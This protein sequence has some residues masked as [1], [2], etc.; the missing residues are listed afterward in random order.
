MNTL[1]DTARNTPS[2]PPPTAYAP[3]APSK[4]D[5]GGATAP[6][7]RAAASSTSGDELTET[8]RAFLGRAERFLPTAADLFPQWER[9]LSAYVV[10]FYLQHVAHQ[11][12]ANL[13]LVRPLYYAW[14]IGFEGAYQLFWFFDVSGVPWPGFCPLALGCAAYNRHCESKD[15]AGLRWPKALEFRIGFMF[16]PARTSKPA[17]PRISLGETRRARRRGQAAKSVLG[18]P[19]ARRGELDAAAKFSRHRR[20]LGDVAILWSVPTRARSKE[21]FRRELGYIPPNAGTWAPRSTPSGRA[22]RPRD[23]RTARPPPTA[24]RGRR[25]GSS[26]CWARTSASSLYR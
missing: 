24:G 21:A 14:F 13:A 8:A 12:H 23:V 1:A 5:A 20:G 22:W 15:R 3:A 18:S 4:A 10:L 19:S 9:I 25:P 17:G 26:T 16:R 6:A 2:P 11:L 7:D